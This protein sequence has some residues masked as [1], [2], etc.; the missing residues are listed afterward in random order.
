M[1][2][3]RLSLT[4]F[5]KYS[6]VS[7]S[8]LHQHSL[9][10]VDLKMKQVMQ[11]QSSAR[12]N[13]ITDRFQRAG[14]LASRLQDG[15]GVKSPAKDQDPTHVSAKVQEMLARKEE[16]G[17]EETA[18]NVFNLDFITKAKFKK[19]AIERRLQGRVGPDQKPPQAL[20]EKQSKRL[21]EQHWLEMID[22]KHRY[23]ANLKWYHKVW[24]ESGTTENFFRW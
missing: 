1:L 10:G 13:S 11:S 15:E 18:E 14:F 16:G 24:S 2:L 3:C 12:R 19:R 22:T 21:E 23:G 20:Q 7:I 6:P 4:V 17:E 5:Q 9:S 8:P